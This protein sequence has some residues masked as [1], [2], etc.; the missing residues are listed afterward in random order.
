MAV[1]LITGVAYWGYDQYRENEQ[2]QIYMGYTFHRSFFD[3]VESVEELQVLIGKG[4]A[5]T[6]PR[7]NILLLTDVWSRANTAQA[8]LNRLPLSAQTVH[9][10]AEFLSKTGDFAHAMA[11]QN[12]DGQ[13]LTSEERQTLN[14]L[15]Q[16]AIRVVERL[17]EVQSDVLAGRI[18][19]VSMVKQTRQNLEEEK[20]SDKEKDRIN[21]DDIRDEMS[22]V[23]VLIYDGPFSDHIMEREPLGLRGEE[24]SKDELRDK[25]RELLDGD[26][27]DL[28]VSEGTDVNGKIP[29]YNFQ[30]KT[31]NGAYSV[32]LAKK[33]GALVSLLNNRDVQSAKIPM[34]Q[35]VDKASSYLARVGFQGMEPTY[36]EIKDNVAY[37]SFAYQQD[38]VLF[39]PDIVNVQVA[40]DNGQVMAVEAMNYLM[41]HKERKTE[42]PEIP[43]EEIRE[44]ASS[45]LESIENIRLAV[46][47][48]S[49]LR[50][51]FTY[52]V[53]G[54]IGDEIYLIYINAKTGNEEEILKVITGEQGTFAL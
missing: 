49:S 35:A 36:S 22:R 47:P 4:L 53:R 12:A 17:H 45:T 41:S 34:D 20:K 9:D 42:K 30:V 3:L 48:K 31:G 18:N 5:S 39:F 6:S 23:P 7:Q 8:E 26:T 27:G 19:W 11:R 2:L 15:R 50:E 32:D 28:S 52:E 25:V 24:M 29:S 13:A 33:G 46:I 54:K 16:H 51:V 43:E 14:Q 1:V 10:V 21:I 38:D 40:L 37:I 44:M